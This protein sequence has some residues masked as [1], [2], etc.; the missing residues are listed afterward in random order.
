[1]PDVLEWLGAILTLELLSEL[2]AS[3]VPFPVDPG[4]AALGDDADVR[5]LYKAVPSSQRSY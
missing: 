2:D 1:M 3:F 4:T 5:F